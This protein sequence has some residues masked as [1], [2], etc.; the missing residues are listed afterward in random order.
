MVSC[1]T[2]N[3]YAI[4]VQSKK[5]DNPDNIL[6]NSLN[7]SLS[8]HLNIETKP[9]AKYQNPSSSSSQD[10]VYTRFHIAL[11]VK[12]KKGHNLVNISRNSLKR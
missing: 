12:S 9:F 10:I 1:F 7:K 6:G 11:M 8:G 2:T 3:N 4:L 5:G